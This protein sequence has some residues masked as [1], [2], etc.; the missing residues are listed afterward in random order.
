[1][2]DR[3]REWLG[4]GVSVQDRWKTKAK[5][6]NGRMTRIDLRAKE[7]FAKGDYRRSEE[8]VVRKGSFGAR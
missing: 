8:G 4:K 1:M 7:R 6:T 2:G 5:L 3:R